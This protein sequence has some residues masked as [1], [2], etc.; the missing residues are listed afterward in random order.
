M[1]IGV[2]TFHWADNYGAV[3]QSFALVKYLNGRGH[4]AEDINYL[5]LRMYTRKR[6][7]QLLFFQTDKLKK[8][9]CFRGFRK[10][11]LRLSKKTYY[12]N[13]SLFTGTDKYDAV[14]CGSDQIWNEVFCMMAERKPTLS[15]FLNFVKNPQKKISYAASFGTN[16]MPTSLAKYALPE[17]RT[18]DFI[19]VRERTAVDM[20]GQNGIKAVL[21]CDPTFLLDAEDY[22][23]IFSSCLGKEKIQLFNYMLRRGRESTD[24]TDDYVKNTIFSGKSNLGAC[25]ITPEEW[26]FQIYSCDCVVTDSFHGT[27]FAILFHKPFLSIND[28]NCT[29]NA[30]IKTLLE[31]VG[32]EDHM[33]EEYD[34]QKIKDILSLSVDWAAV[35]ALRKEWKAEAEGFLTKALVE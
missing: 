9:S 21:V 26:L 20:L 31:R 16:V 23:E 1:K 35:D 5:P 2:M 8:A 3:L 27:V 4:S 15:Y 12:S 17:L 18:F 34:E 25:T 10:K 7:K 19:S 11:F 14:I 33:L 22:Q 13:R 29:M 28:K 6:I 30:R 32:L 24:N